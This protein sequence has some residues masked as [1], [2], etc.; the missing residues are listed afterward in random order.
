M[1]VVVQ[2]LHSFYLRDAER[3]R[4]IGDG[5]GIERSNFLP[6]AQHFEN[7]QNM[8]SVELAIIGYVSCD[9]CMEEGQHLIVVKMIRDDN[10]RPCAEEVLCRSLDL[11]THLARPLRRDLDIATNNISIYLLS[12]ELCENE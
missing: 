12:R 10:N 5:D 8:E 9:I 4:H 1:C 7:I 2:L 6:T 3:V 11:Q